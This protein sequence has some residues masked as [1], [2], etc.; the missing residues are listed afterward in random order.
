MSERHDSS[1]LKL[2][3]ETTQSNVQV[4]SEQIQNWMTSLDAFVRTV[5]LSDLDEAKKAEIVSHIDVIRTELR[6]GQWPSRGRPPTSPALFMKRVTSRRSIKIGKCCPFSLRN[7]C[8]PCR[9][10]SV[11]AEL[12]EL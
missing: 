7:G 11:S 1:S 10:L 4:P 6:S 2:E 9:T 3:P 12:C 8:V 5:S